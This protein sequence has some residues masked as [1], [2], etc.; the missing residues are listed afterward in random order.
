MLGRI[1]SSLVR[2]PLFLMLAAA[3]IA[4]AIPTQLAA[5]FADSCDSQLSRTA[6]RYA[7]RIPRLGRITRQPRLAASTTAPD[8]PSF[9]RDEATREAAVKRRDS[10]PWS[11]AVSDADLHFPHAAE[12]FS[13]AA[14]LP[15]SKS[16]R[17][18]LIRCLAKRSLT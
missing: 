1:W 4:A 10:G 6:A 11:R 12:S 8:S 2:E 7:A 16:V 9:A 14:N 3:L 5:Q 15:I 17:R 13:C 18:S